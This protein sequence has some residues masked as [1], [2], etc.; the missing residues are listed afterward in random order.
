M[1]RF[2][3]E[4][5]GVLLTFLPGLTSNCDSPGL[6]LPSSWDYR[7]ELLCPNFE[8]LINVNV[9]SEH[10]VL[11]HHVYIVDKIHYFKKEQLIDICLC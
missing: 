4:L 7:Y 9:H 2:F 10:G 11:S 8:I 6:C 5:Y 1:L 3:V